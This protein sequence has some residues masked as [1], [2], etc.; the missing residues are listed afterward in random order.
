MPGDHRRAVPGG[1]RDVKS[2]GRLNPRKKALSKIRFCFLAASAPLAFRPSV[3]ASRDT[4]KTADFRHFSLIAGSEPRR[5]P[6]GRVS[7]DPI[8]GGA[9]GRRR[10]CVSATWASHE[11]LQGLGAR[12]DRPSIAGRPRA[13][14]GPKCAH[15][16][17]ND[18]VRAASALERVRAE[19]ERRGLTYRQRFSG[20]ASSPPQLRDGC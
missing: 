6:V 7:P 20:W 14:E 12:T 15:G 1:A 3:T 8:A 4:M 11:A 2:I 18:G 10:G 13:P 9:R 16:L 17:L 19:R 5:W